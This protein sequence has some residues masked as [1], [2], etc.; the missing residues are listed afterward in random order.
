MSDEATKPE[1]FRLTLTLRDPRL[2]KAFMRFRGLIER[3]FN[4]EGLNEMYRRVV[5]MEGD[6]PFLEKTLKA[7]NLRFELSAAD[8]ARIPATGPL[9][10]VSNHPFGAVD[11]FLLLTLLR[12]VRPDAKLLANF[13]LER[14]P[15]LRDCFIF[16]DPFGTEQSARANVAGMKETLRWL[17][18]GGALAILPAGE[19]AHLDWRRREVCDP[20]WS[21]SVARIIR[22]TQ[23]PVLPI[24]IAGSNSLFFQLVG[25]LHPR[26]RTAM[27]PRE[28]LN[29][30]DHTFQLRV[31]QLI[32]PARMTELT[33]DA[34]LMKYLRVRTHIL[35][36]REAGGEADGRAGR[37]SLFARDEAPLAPPVPADLIGREVDNLPANQRLLTHENFQVCYA[38]A[39]QVPHT[40]REIGR[41]RELTF[42]KANEGTGQ[43]VDLDRFDAYYLHLFLWNA[44]RREIVGAY[45][46]GQTD[47]ILRQHGLR[48]LYTR[49][50]FRY[51]HKLLRQLNPALEL[52]RSFV[53]PEYQKNYAALLLLW[54]G[55]GAFIAQHPR[56][57]NLFGPVSINNEYQSTSRQLLARFLSLNRLAPGLAGL[58]RP[59]KPLRAQPIRE[60]DMHALS[61]VIT[62]VDEVSDLIAEI[63]KDQKGI[64]ILL[65][66]YLKLGGRL[67][68]FNVDPKFSF[69]LDGLV[70]VDLKDTDAKIMLRYMGRA[71]A[72]RFRA[73]HRLDTPREVGAPD[74]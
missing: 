8:R 24:F 14:I 53:R 55:I 49:T 15:D 73:W 39:E 30:V 72:Q 42:R 23:A 7:M 38:R 6:E 9:I 5:A 2:Q 60:V 36:S 20:P 27:L 37:R 63:E 59:R 54:K 26:L 52:G 28:F 10:V 50:L 47:V 58:I 43:P 66:Q 45:R 65:K 21:E 46:M 4:L 74:A 51:G 19:V 33:S 11:G 57:R 31:G 70:W 40:L 48:G 29:K 69:V 67:L 12:R 35:A 44:E 56:Y 22:R 71:G 64:P 18:Q 61:R 1:P 32:P 34:D 41:L 17:K 16:V 62:D 13:M 68:A 3:C 25:M